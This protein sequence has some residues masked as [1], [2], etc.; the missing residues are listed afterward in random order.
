[1]EQI[2]EINI[3]LKREHNLCVNAMAF[4]RKSLLEFEAKYRLST[5]TF[6]KKFEDG[7]IGDEADYFDWYAFA[8]LLNRLK[9]TESALR[10]AI[11]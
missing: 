9:K 2:N 8:K 3:S 6:L 11:Q 4:Y 1:M 5:K 7:K 10:S